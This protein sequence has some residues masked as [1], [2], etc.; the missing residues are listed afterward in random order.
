MGGNAVIR[1]D[2]LARAGD[3]LDCALAHRHALARV[4]RRRHVPSPARAWRARSIRAGTHHLT[5]TCPQRDWP[6]GTSV[7]W[8]FWRGVSLGVMDRDGPRRSHIW[9]G[10][11]D[12]GSAARPKRL[13]ISANPCA[14][15]RS[16]AAQ[17]FESELAC[18]GPRRLFLGQARLGARSRAASGTPAGAP[19][20][21]GGIRMSPVPDVS[22]VLPTYNRAAELHAQSRACLNQTARP[23]STSSSSSTTTP[24][25]KPRRSWTACCVSTPGRVRAISERSRVSPTRERWHSRAPAPASSRSS[26][27]TFA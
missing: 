26:T 4:R 14:G 13:R 17:R 10:F 25:M 1:R 24:R 15:R 5:T 8:C 22:V 16:A 6:R 27:T 7:R 18:V 11:R 19:G 23:D 2:A 9:L 21:A 20:R 3:V 12:T